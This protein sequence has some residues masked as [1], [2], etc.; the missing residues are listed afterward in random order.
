MLSRM[1]KVNILSRLGKE[2]TEEGVRLWKLMI[3]CNL[4]DIDAQ[5]TKVEKLK[6]NIQTERSQRWK[7]W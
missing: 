4:M 3:N 1:K 7:G 6:D 5:E 2:N